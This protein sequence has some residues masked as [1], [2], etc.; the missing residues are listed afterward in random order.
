MYKVL[1]IVFNSLN[2]LAHEYLS[3]LLAY[4]GDGHSVNLAE[5]KVNTIH[6]EKSF[7]KAG[8]KLWNKLPNDVKCAVSLPSFKSLLKT[9]LFEQAHGID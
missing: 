3:S 5:P 4:Y 2:G 6:G 9:H 7:Q 8:H 1:L